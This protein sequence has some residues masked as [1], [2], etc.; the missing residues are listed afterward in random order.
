VYISLT[1][2]AT[3]IAGPGAMQ[4]ITSY[5]SIYHKPGVHLYD[6]MTRG[7]AGTDPRMLFSWYA[8]DYCTDPP[9]ADLDPESRANPSRATWADQG[10]LDQQRVRLPSHKFRRL[11]LNLPGLPEGSAFSIESLDRAITRGVSVVSREPGRKYHAF[12][13]TSGGSSD[14]A[15]LAIGYRDDAGVNRVVR[16]LNQAPDP[17]ST[18]ASP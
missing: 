5:A 11:H 2:C 17:R 15:V 1:E 18:R 7:K 12:V 14:D 6:L 16:G 3:T 4:W 9:F 10:Y 13:D 8:A